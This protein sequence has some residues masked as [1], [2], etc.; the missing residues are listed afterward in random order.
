MTALTDCPVT[1]SRNMRTPFH[2]FFAILDRCFQRLSHTMQRIAGG[3]SCE[4]IYDQAQTPRNRFLEAAHR[5]SSSTHYK[6]ASTSD[7]PYGYF[8]GRHII[9]ECTRIQGGIYVGADPH[10]AIV[11]DEKY[12]TLRNVYNQLVE[13][14]KDLPEHPT[15]FEYHV[16][17]KVIELS[18]RVLAYRPEDTDQIC[19][20]EEISHDEK[21]ALDVFISRRAGLPRHQVLLAAFLLEKLRS[22][23]IIQGLPALDNAITAQG[24]NREALLYTSENGTVLRFDPLERAIAEQVH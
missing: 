24:D 5:L 14:L 22:E 20:N 4:K 21:V 7:A 23:S 16:F 13:S 12:G 6:S 1:D 9:G 11:I 18:R 8:R 15:H 2:S 19:D 17:L 10:E 3:S